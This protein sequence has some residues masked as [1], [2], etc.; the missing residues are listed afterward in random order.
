MGSAKV[1]HE[2]KLFK[3]MKSKWSHDTFMLYSW[4]ID[5]PLFVASLAHVVR[6]P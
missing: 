6:P 3:F 4:F 5:Q 1:M 2:F